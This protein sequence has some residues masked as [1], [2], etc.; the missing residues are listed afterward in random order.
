QRPSTDVITGT[1]KTNIPSRIA[2]AV[3]SAIDSRII[4][5]QVGA[6]RLLGYGDMLYI[7]MGE[8]APRRIQGVFVSDDEINRITEFVKSQG[9]PLYDDAFVVGEGAETQ[10]M[11]M[12]SADPLYDDVKK[13]VA[14]TGKASTSSIQ[15]YFGFGYNRAARIIDYLEQEGAIGPA[16][17]SKPREVYITADDY[18]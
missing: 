18:K 6:E 11:G 14:T 16:N 10:M 13:F 3:S 12:T 8:S 4:L 5:D 2:F 17:G 15:R 1:I 9:K 7:P